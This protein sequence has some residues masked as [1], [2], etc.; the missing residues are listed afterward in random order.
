MKIKLQIQ[1]VFTVAIA[2]LFAVSSHA[3]NRIRTADDQQ[4]M[5]QLKHYVETHPLAKGQTNW[6]VE[7]LKKYNAAFINSPSLKD[8]HAEK[9]TSHSNRISGGAPLNDECVNATMLTEQTSCISTTGDVLGATT[10]MLPD[11][12]NTYISD[13]ALDV[14][15]QFVAV[16]SNPYITV[17]GS[18][19]F[20]AVVFLFDACGGSILGC[21][22]ASVNGQSETIISSGLTPSNTY[23]IRVYE[24]GNAIPLTTTFDICVFNAPPPP[25]NDDCANAIL[26]SED[27]S[28]NPV[29]GD[30]AWATESIPPDVC[31]TFTS[32]QGYD[33]WYKFV[34]VTSS[35]LISVTGSPQFDPVV[36][37]SSDCAG[38]VIA[39]SDTSANGGTEL[40]NA[41]GLT[42]GTTYYIRV[43]DYGN[44]LPPT[45]TFDIC[46]YTAPVGI[47]DIPNSSLP[48]LF[49]NPTKGI[50]NIRFDSVIEKNTVDVYDV[51][52]NLVQQRIFHHSKEAKL[53]VSSLANGVYYVQVQNE[54]G[55]FTQKLILNK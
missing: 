24:Y 47:A 13:S 26:L 22:D 25:V 50:F 10:S 33:V 1:N 32:A 17:T 23:Y 7:T 51:L 28:C 55:A 34:A 29:S 14:W 53:D 44:A 49:P 9:T 8:V 30:V 38:S 48:F 52:G 27:V 37:L 16:T 15:Y 40:F 45:T 35:P 4:K 6:A 19:S 43:Y 2:L 46:V 3:Q 31:T 39:C 42:I 18:A 12:C 20:D 41:S 21:S 11:S 5:E 36:F 54:N